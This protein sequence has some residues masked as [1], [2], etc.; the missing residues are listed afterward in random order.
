MDPYYGQICLF[1]FNYAPRNWI[2]CD[3]RLLSI[4]ENSALFALLGTTYGG[5]GVTNFGLPDLRGRVPVG[6]NNSTYRLGTRGGVETER[7]DVSQMPEHDHTGIANVETKVTCSTNVADQNNPSGNFPAISK[8]IDRQTIPMYNGTGGALMG[9]GATT[10]VNFT[11]TKTGGNV[12]LNIV[13]P[14]LAIGYYICING[15]FPPRP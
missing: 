7:I 9:G 13:Q 5:N 8:E 3:G 10:S 15:V 4:G 14:Y 11:T 12:N 2:L 1:A 6:A